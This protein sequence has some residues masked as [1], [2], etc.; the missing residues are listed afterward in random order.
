ML[1]IVYPIRPVWSPSSSG[2]VDSALV[3]LRL[4]AIVEAADVNL[5]A[6][7]DFLRNDKIS[8]DFNLIHHCIHLKSTHIVLFV[9]MYPCVMLPL[10]FI[11]WIC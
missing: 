6:V 8:I 9:V 10:G 2:D 4:V 5:T 3:A 11:F 7:H 1:I